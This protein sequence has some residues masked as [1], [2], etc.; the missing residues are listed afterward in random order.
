MPHR[1][2]REAHRPKHPF[3]EDL[4]GRIAEFVDFE[5]ALRN[6]LAL[7]Q[8]LAQAKELGTTEAIVLQIRGDCGLHVSLLRDSVQEWLPGAQAITVDDGRTICFY[9]L[10]IHTALTALDKTTVEVLDSLRS[11]QG[12]GDAYTRYKVAVEWFCGKLANLREYVKTGVENWGWPIDNSLLAKIGAAPAELACVPERR[13]S[14]DAEKDGNQAPADAPKLGQVQ[15]AMLDD[16]GV[17]VLRV[18]SNPKMSVDQKMRE[19]IRLDLRYGGFNSTRWA[20]MLEVTSQAIRQTDC[21]KECHPRKPGA[22]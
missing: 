4:C 16:T 2:R 12:H 17:E 21:W 19:L 20:E 22:Q 3:W 18:L 5:V 1:A 13:I 15:A 9:P 6:S 7:L 14:A 10:D 8:E 11:G